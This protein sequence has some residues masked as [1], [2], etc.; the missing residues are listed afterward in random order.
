MPESGRGQVNFAI[1][2]IL[3]QVGCVTLLAIGAALGV[4]LW[5]DSQFHT[6][7]ILTLVLMLGSVPVSIYAMV[8]IVLTGMARIQRE[9][10]S[11]AQEQRGEPD[12][13]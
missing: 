3:G 7:P 9:A 12:N 10:Q 5:L 13:D 8:R 2:G 1:A 11:T 6:R 4:G